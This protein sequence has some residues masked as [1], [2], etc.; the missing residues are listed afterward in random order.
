MLDLA[1]FAAYYAAMN[2]A[3]DLSD[4]VWQTDNQALG[5]A[6]D[7]LPADHP[8][9]A[10][11]AEAYRS[12]AGHVATYHATQL[13]VIAALRATTG[14]PSW[15]RVAAAVAWSAAT[16]AF[17]DR[18][19]PVK[20]LL[21]ATGSPGF[22]TG[23]QQLPA[24]RLDTTGTAT[25]PTTIPVSIPGPYV[26]DQALHHVVRVLAAALLAWRR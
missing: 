15:R 7:Q 17:L 4:H 2:A 16:H 26:A 18:R 19:W 25:V 5:K 6:A 10:T 9:R 13:G 24:L 3:D 1:R 23:Q 22:A 8:G 14:G 12:L 11:R 20:K 21:A